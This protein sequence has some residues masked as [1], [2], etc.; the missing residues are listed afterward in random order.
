[1]RNAGYR[2][3]RASRRSPR[4]PTEAPWDTPIG[5]MLDWWLEVSCCQGNVRLSLE[6][7]AYNHGRGRTLRNVVDHLRCREC[8]RQPTGVRLLRN[9]AVQ[10]GRVETRRDWMLLI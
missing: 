4:I 2:P 10:P 1:M 3:D 6:A 9:D 7:V 8:G 5:D